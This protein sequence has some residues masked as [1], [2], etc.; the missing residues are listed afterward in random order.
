[1]GRIYGFGAFRLDPGCRTL[2]RDDQPVPLTPRVFDTLVALV[3]H[4]GTVVPKED[5]LKAVWGE[6]FVEENN[7]NQSISSL[8]KALGNDGNGNRYIATVPRKGYSFVASVTEMESAD[9]LST[10]VVPTRE[11]SD[12]SPPFE[13]PAQ[14]ERL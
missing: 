4:H 1:M 10:A 13:K 6:T 12:A 11:P 9:A 2:L 14:R 7:L 8:R 3:S 5:L